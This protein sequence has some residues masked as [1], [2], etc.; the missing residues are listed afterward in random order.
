M[1]STF[2]IDFMSSECFQKFDFYFLLLMYVKSVSFFDLVFETEF[3]FADTRFE[4]T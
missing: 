1:I 3:L 4:V 2:Y